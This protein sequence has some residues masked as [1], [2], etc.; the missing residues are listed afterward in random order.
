MNDNIPPTAIADLILRL[1]NPGLDTRDGRRRATADARLIYDGADGAGPVE[2]RKFPVSAP[3]GPIEREEIDWYLERY[4]HWPSDFVRDR[5]Q[6]VERSLPKWGRDVYELLRHD[7]AREAF[8]AWRH[9]SG[10]DKR[11][12]VLLADDEDADGTDEE[13]R[14]AADEGAVQL[15][16]LPWEL[17]H[18]GERYLFQGKDAVRVRRQLPNRR[19]RELLRTEL[20][21]RVLLAS[22]RPLDAGYIDHRVSAR[23][24]VDAFAELGDLARL[25]ILEPPHF[26]ALEA[27]LARAERDGEPYHV[28][29]FD[30]HGVYD[31]QVGLGALCFERPQDAGQLERREYELVT[32]DKLA[33]SLAGYR[34]PLFFLEACQ[35]AKTEDDPTASV[36]RRLLEGGVASVVAMSHTVLVET[37]RRFADAFYRELVHGRRVG[38]AMLAGQ[39]RLKSDTFRSKTYVGDL[40]LEDWFVPVLFQEKTD[41]ALVDTAGLDLA[42]SL[43]AF[44]KRHRQALGALPERPPHGF[45]GRSRELLRAERLLAREPFIVWKGEGGEGKTTIGVELARWLV[46]TRRFEQAAFV[47]LE[48]HPDARSFLF[49]LGEQLVPGFVAQA[50]DDLDGARTSLLDALAERPTVIVVDNVETVL[51]QGDDAFYEP[52]VLEAILGDCRAF[53]DVRTARLIFTTREPLPPPFDSQAHVFDLGRLSQEDAVEL[54]GKVL[55]DGERMP[56]AADE[57]TSDEEVGKLVE[58]VGAH[59]RSLVLLTGEVKASGVEGATERIR[60]MMERLAARYPNDRERSLYASVELS[61]RRLPAEMRERARRL[62]VCPGGVH[63]AVIAALWK[64]DAEEAKGVAEALARVG[65]GEMM[66]YGHV[67][68]HPALAPYLDR[69]VDDAEREEARSHW[70]GAMAQ[71]VAFLYQQQRGQ[72]P[73][74]AASLTL[75]ELPNLLVLVERLREIAQADLTVSVATQ[76]E[77]LLQTLGRPRAMA[78]VVA[79]REAAAKELGE[80]SH[81]QFLAETL[82][83]ERLLDGGHPIEAFEAAS[84]LRQRCLTGGEDAYDGADYD[85][86]GAHDLLGKVLMLSGSAEQALKPLAEALERFQKLA[87]G[88]SSSAESMVAVCT[89]RIGTCLRHLG[90]LDQ[91]ASAYGTSIDLAEKTGNPRIA[92]V[93]R[94]QLGTVF[95][96]QRKYKQALAAYAEA[97]KT[98]E[99]L[100]EPGSVAVSWHQTGYVYQEAGMVDAAEDAYHQSLKIKVQQENRQG[101]AST[102]NQLGNL[103]SSTGR[104]EEAVRFYRQAADIF[105]RA[106]DLA[107]EG[108]ARGNVADELIKLQRYD[109]ARQEILR[110]IECHKDFGHSVEPWKAYAILHNLERAV[111]NDEEA[112]R[113]REQAV[114]AF[115]AY[116]RAGG[117][118]HH[119]SGRLAALVAQAVVDGKGDAIVPQLVALLDGDDL[120][121]KWRPFVRVLRAVAEGSR[122]AA[123]ASDPGMR[124][125]EVVELRLLLEAVATAG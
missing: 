88:G 83:V 13:A 10:V 55:G 32:A 95:L 66:E 27:E 94:G 61:L 3:I 30:G 73:R 38:E 123:L 63:L 109:E 6:E 18:D 20:P 107:N 87:E 68:L 46:E 77:G 97:R 101:E 75:L 40:H 90:Q 45:V 67:R 89:E 37:T 102:L 58:A 5:A 16:A 52:Q 103:Y 59:A 24:L 74:M 114:E 47:S 44:E 122:D 110:V 43:R 91:A 9:A 117:E 76:V 78:R 80:W 104:R 11:F 70:I 99:A 56:G 124:Y 100:N 96:Q 120:P 113:A 35:T 41:P 1:T 53:R 42:G 7:E 60:E 4:S 93:G 28:V 36:A 48:D 116:R 31:P 17:A 82:K 15:L 8:E 34:V 22:P 19:P 71:M 12:S 108:R 115:L 111:G 84:R 2:S 65:L 98:F 14:T 118:N 69:E 25:T 106:G 86:A 125:D 50:A 62:A 85:V 112:V 29:H 57:A 39:Q 49:A 121:D 54:V 119:D 72:D 79:L 23:P 81:A 51:A 105:S 64:A 33:E 26:A 21:I 92:A